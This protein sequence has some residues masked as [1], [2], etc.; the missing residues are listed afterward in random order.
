MKGAGTYITERYVD[1]RTA[2]R[3]H[4]LKFGKYVS[5]QI[6]MP[7]YDHSGCIWS[8]T[9]GIP[10][11]DKRYDIL[12]PPIQL[13]QLFLADVYGIE[14]FVNPVFG[15]KKGYD[16]WEILGY[17]ADVNWRDEYGLFYLSNDDFNRMRLSEVEADFHGEFWAQQI[18]S[19]KANYT[20]ALDDAVREAVRS[21]T[22]ENLYQ[23]WKS[24]F[25]AREKEFYK[26]LKDQPE[27]GK[28]LYFDSNYSDLNSIMKLDTMISKSRARY[29]GEY[30]PKF[31]VEI[32][33]NLGAFR[34]VDASNN[35]Y[36]S[37]VAHVVDSIVG[38]LDLIDEEEE[39][40]R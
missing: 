7:H 4:D 14:I 11:N 33:W 27:F 13:V 5:K 34:V 28:Y 37:A 32:E 16:S 15:K 31:W 23:K 19:P 35:L 20:E 26:N 10:D 39:K 36:L 22:D 38:I 21:L 12:C 3:L 9:I 17:K 24:L 6:P 2:K 40:K 25:E 1:F 29:I 8:P 18:N 30:N